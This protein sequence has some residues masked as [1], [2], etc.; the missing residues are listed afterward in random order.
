MKNFPNAEF[1][2]VA[3]GHDA[4]WKDYLE[5]VFQKISG[6]RDYMPICKRSKAALPKG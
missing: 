3:G 1:K 4:P 2:I 6:L 5:E